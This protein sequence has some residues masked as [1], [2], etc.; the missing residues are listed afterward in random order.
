[1]AGDH[2]ASYGYHELRDPNQLYNVQAHQG[3]LCSACYG[4]PRDVVS[5]DPSSKV[6]MYDPYHAVRNAHRRATSICI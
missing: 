6:T 3:L 2:S 4:L 1:M 5:R